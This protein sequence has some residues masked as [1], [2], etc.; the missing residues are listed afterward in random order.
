M[1]RVNI[2]RVSQRKISFTERFFQ[3]T[4]IKSH[5]EDSKSFLICVGVSKYVSSLFSKHFRI[6]RVNPNEFRLDFSQ[7]EIVYVLV[8]FE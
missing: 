4:P 3:A 2:E 1:N 5:T 8:N 7:A 6:V